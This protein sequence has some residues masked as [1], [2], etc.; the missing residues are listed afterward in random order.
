MLYVCAT[1]IGNMKDIS[2]RALELLNLADII[3]CE[4]TRTSHKL[5]SFHGIKPKKLV[6]FHQHNENEIA[7]K[8]LTWLADDLLI[9]QISDAGTPGISDPG[10]RL[11]KILFDNGYEPSPLPGA[12]AYISLLSVSGILSKEH[13]FIGFL[14]SKSSHRIKE[15]HQ[16][17][18]SE[19][20]VILYESPH[21]IIDCI[22]D[23]ISVHGTTKEL[24]IG[25][26][27]TKMF[28]TIKRAN[29]ADI[30]N[31]ISSAKNQQK[32][33]FV[34]ILLPRQKEVNLFNS[35]TEQQVKTID[36]L[37]KELPPKKASQ[38][39]S[40]ILELN[41]QD[42]YDYILSTKK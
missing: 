30:L 4:D 26:E 37:S 39:A 19:Y 5:L 1:P 7:N 25:R 15:L 10:A 36:L 6:A 11:C 21:R 3:S 17:I 18:D 31:F 38:I 42:I 20:P 28:E 40:Q 2:L 23:I 14:S 34:L 16:Y 35:L 27:L 13:L 12:C 24:L 32:G 29:A 8:V 22:K 9:I 33:E 41:K